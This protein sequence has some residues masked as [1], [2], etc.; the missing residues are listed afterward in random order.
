MYQ[1]NNVVYLNVICQIYL[2]FLKDY[3]SKSMY[4]KRKNTQIGLHENKIYAITIEINYIT[5]AIK[6]FFKH[7]NICASLLTHEIKFSSGF[8]K[9]LKFNL[10]FCFPFELVAHLTQSHLFP[11]REH[12][13]ISDLSVKSWFALFRY[14][15]WASHKSTESSILYFS[16]SEPFRGGHTSFRI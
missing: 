16:S 14:R 4:I 15:Q 8:N 9:Y 10:G 3:N 13:S 7:G 11:P 2:H 12:R 5:I 1:I 6:I